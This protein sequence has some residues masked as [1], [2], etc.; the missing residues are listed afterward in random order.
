[1]L[2]NLD[3]MILEDQL[4]HH[5]VRVDF[6]K[7]DGTL[8]SMLCTKNPEIITEDHMPSAHPIS[9]DSVPSTPPTI[10][11]VFDL[12]KQAWRSMR[13]ANITAWELTQ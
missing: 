4:A 3:Q 9:A 6:N 7:V 12:E 2:D 10:L 8:R 13:I 11:R 5:R 1:M